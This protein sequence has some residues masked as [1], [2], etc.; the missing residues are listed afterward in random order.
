MG[1][2]KDTH[3]ESTCKGIESY[4]DFVHEIGRVAHAHKRTALVNIVLP[5]IDLVIILQG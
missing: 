2:L 5:P 3:S 4:V 1:K